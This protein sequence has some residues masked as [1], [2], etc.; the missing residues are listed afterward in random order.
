MKEQSVGCFNMTSSHLIT[1]LMLHEPFEGFPHD[2]NVSKW[3]RFPG[4]AHLN[5]DSTSKFG[6]ALVPQ[7]LALPEILLTNGV[8]NQP[9]S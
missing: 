3:Y 1:H 8:E 5:H 9:I 4:K 2:S 6:V 7:Y